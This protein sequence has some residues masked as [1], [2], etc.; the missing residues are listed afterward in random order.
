LH[1]PLIQV[2]DLSFSYQ[3][4]TILSHISFDVFSGEFIGIIGPNGGGKTTLL[5]V[6]MGFLKPYSGSV[7][8]FGK[9]PGIQPGERRRLAYVPQ[10]TRFDREFPI[11]ALEVVL[12]GLLAELPWY[13]IFHR[14]QKLAA[15]DALDKVGM[16]KYSDVSFGTL[17]GGQAQRVL[18]ARALVSRPQLLLLD[19]PTASVDSKAEAEIYSILKELKGKLTILMV[20][21]DL[22]AAVEHVER[23][24]CVQGKVFSLQ[25]EEICEHFAFGLYHT[26]L[27]QPGIRGDG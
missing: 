3:N 17:S 23:L 4:T 15:L 6:L 24:L 27:L 2:Q 9:D 20:T 22:R 1:H 10:A 14:R 19:E 11:S 26:P 16:K 12:S 21:H 13:G 8:V 25:P 7:K 18:I 5:K